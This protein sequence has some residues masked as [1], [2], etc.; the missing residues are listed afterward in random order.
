[1]ARYLS[2]MSTPDETKW[3][4]RGVPR[5]I[6]DQEWP[7][8]KADIDAGRPSPLG[9]VGGERTFVGDV[10]GKLSML[11]HCHQVLAYGYTLD[12]H[13]QLELRVYD[14]N[15]PRTDTST[16]EISLA[17]PDEESPI[18]TARITARISG[19]GTFRAFFRHDHYARVRPPVGVSPGV[20]AG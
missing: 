18:S 13:K 3:F 10:V 15:D 14:P 6:A 2:L 17:D 16:I 12:D 1:M 8:I 20:V 4:V 19:H 11:G 7:K 9:L 5:I